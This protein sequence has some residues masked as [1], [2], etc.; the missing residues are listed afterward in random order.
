MHLQYDDDYV[1]QLN[2]PSEEKRKNFSEKA[3][4]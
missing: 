1:E 2:Q 3:G 4:P